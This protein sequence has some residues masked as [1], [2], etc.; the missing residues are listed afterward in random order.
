LEHWHL[1]SFVNLLRTS[2][3]F[4]QLAIDSTHLPAALDMR[5]Y[6]IES[7]LQAISPGFALLMHPAK[8]LHIPESDELHKRGLR[9]IACVELIKGVVVLICAVAVIALLK[10][11][12]DLEEAAQNLL[13]MLQID[14]E[15]RLSL[16]FVDAAG[17]VQDSNLMLIGAA[18]S[19]YGLM[20]FVEGYGLWRKRVWAEWFALLSGLVYLPLE[21]REL[22]HGSTV[23]KWLVLVTNIVIVGYIAYLRISA[24]NARHATRTQGAPA[25]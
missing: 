8:H 2:H 18:A 24:H 22:L 11:D 19:L 25:D 12:F 21:I 17:R 6:V 5:I 9:T 1:K 3:T 4:N 23:F 14:P 16:L 13:Y 15:K 10:R 7:R 20:R